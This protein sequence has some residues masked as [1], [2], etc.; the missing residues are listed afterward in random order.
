MSCFDH[1][2]SFQAKY[3]LEMIGIFIKHGV[4]LNGTSEQPDNQDV[5]H[6]N[7]T[8]LQF[9]I[10][11]I[12]WDRCGWSD[13]EKKLVLEKLFEEGNANP[14]LKDRHGNDALKLALFHRLPFEAF[15]VVA[16]EAVKNAPPDLFTSTNRVGINVIQDAKSAS[17]SVRMFLQDLIGGSTKQ[18]PGPSTQTEEVNPHQT[19]S[20]SKLRRM[21]AQQKKQ[22]TTGGE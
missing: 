9:T 13:I 3:A 15:K 8:C 17:D 1:M 19:I 4:D 18:S 16:L 12:M 10:M 7:K 5:R 20:K 11:A 21:K 2:A 22:R 14:H 6:T